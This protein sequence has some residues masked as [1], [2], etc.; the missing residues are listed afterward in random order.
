MLIPPLQTLTMLGKKK[1]RNTSA[2]NILSEK[3]A[4]RAAEL[5]IK[6]TTDILY[7]MAVLNFPHEV[8]MDSK[9]THNH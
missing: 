5:D 7:S 1:V 3:L 2:L 8:I 6:Q 4:T 9:I